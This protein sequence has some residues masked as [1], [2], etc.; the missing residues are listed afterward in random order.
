MPK[1]INVVFM[2]TPDFAVPSLKALSDYGC[3]VPLVI[4]RADQPK[5]R[6]RKIAAP[7]VKLTALELNYPVI[8]PNTL[9]NENIYEKILQIHPDLVVVVAFGHILPE[10][11]LKIPTFGAINIH[12]SLLPKYRGPAP[13]QRSIINGD[14]ETGIT[15]MQMDKG[16]DTG[17]ILLSSKEPIFPDDTAKTLHDRLADAG[18]DL[19]K[20]AL[21]RIENK[22]IIPVPQDHPNA[23]Y[24][25]MLYKKEG[26]IDWSLSADQIERLI[27]GMTPWPGA[28]TFYGKKRLKIFKATLKDI[29]S[30]SEPGK[31]I[32]GFS[33]ELRV[34]TGDG[35]L[36]ITELQGSSGKRL[37]ITDFLRG[38]SIPAGTVLT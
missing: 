24:A 33:N 21:A 17:D 9:K 22:T 13:I 29:P 30:S 10:K 37:S 1:R 25:P 7:P 6:G 19:L 4:T 20:N 38:T 27:R 32:Q 2:G 23:T 31:V 28:Y 16:L 14:T 26:R 15:I 3:R 11:I 35:V 18:A 5:G 8:Q 36:S 12:A 34:T